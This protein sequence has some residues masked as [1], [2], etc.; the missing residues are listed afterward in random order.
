MKSTYFLLL[1][2]LHLSLTGWAQETDA[3]TKNGEIGLGL[4]YGLGIN[5]ASVD[6]GTAPSGELSFLNFAA[7][8]EK[9]YSN[10]FALSGELALMDKSYKT[11]NGFQTINSSFKYI[12]LN[13][14]PKLK[15]GNENAEGFIFAGPGLNLKASAKATANGQSGDVTDVAGFDISGIIGAGVAF[16]AGSGKLFMDARYNIGLMDISTETPSQY[17]VKLSQIGIGFGYLHSF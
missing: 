11:S 5:T 12:S 10:Q 13:I 17:S 14:L 2:L 16:N 15:F 7:L 1:I 4:R 8:L 6:P 9:S 3:S